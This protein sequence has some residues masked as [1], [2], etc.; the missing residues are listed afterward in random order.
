MPAGIFV[1]EGFRFNRR[2]GGLFRLDSGAKIPIGSRAL[3]ILGVLIERAGDL[4]SK[5]ELMAAVWPHTVVDD[6]NL[7][8]QISAL[9]RVLDDGRLGGSSIQT[10]PGRGYRFVG[11]VASCDGAPEARVAAAPGDVIGTDRTAGLGTSEAVFEETGGE[12]AA[13]RGPASVRKQR[14][15]RPFGVALSLI[16]CMLVVTAIGSFRSSD[17]RW[18]AQRA[19]PTP[20]LSV[21]VLPFNNLSDDRAQQ[22]FTDAVTENLT[23]D[24]SRIEGSI[25]ISRNSAYTYKDKAVDAKRVGREL[26]VRYVV[27]GSL[28]RSA[29]TLASVDR[30]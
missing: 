30:R 14:F 9:R 8:V 5:D 29:S 20:R 3:D 21:V 24:L 15:G 26:G 6:G 23:T 19:T 13:E 18:F 1:F 28:Q 7:T 2:G 25:V 10:V 16:A 11:A 4:V 22:Y 17:Y 12:T 27:E